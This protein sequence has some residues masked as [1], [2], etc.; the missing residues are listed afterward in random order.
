MLKLKLTEI[1]WSIYN[2]NLKLYSVA[3]IFKIIQLLLKVSFPLAN[4]LI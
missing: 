1:L 2:D 3:S 4:F